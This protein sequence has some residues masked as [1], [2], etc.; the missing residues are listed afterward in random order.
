MM[1]R[2]ILL[3]LFLGVLAWRPLKAQVEIYRG[4]SDTATYIAPEDTI[5][6]APV[7]GNDPD[8][9]Y[10]YIA[11]Q[12]NMTLYGKFLDYYPENFRFSFY[13]ERNG[14][15]SDFKSIFA[16]DPIVMDEIERIIIHM[17]EWSPGK[18]D[19]KRRR[20][21]MEYNVTIQL[22]EDIPPVLVTKNELVTEFS[23][24]HKNFKWFA[25]AGSVLI[26]LTLL[27][28]QK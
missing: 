8:E 24:K 27:I 2:C 22:T 14:K 21:L 12:Y 18:Q 26:M 13:V 19:G 5:T 6:R 15:V 28:S 20:T 23:N 4:S 11:Q 25:V 10:R 16:S 7:F 3:V 9:I 1:R 17:P